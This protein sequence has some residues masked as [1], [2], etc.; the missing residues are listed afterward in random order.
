MSRILAVSQPQGNGTGARTSPEDYGRVSESKARTS[1][2]I[3]RSSRAASTSTRGPGSR[4]PSSASCSCTAELAA[5]SSS[6]AEEPQPRAG[7]HTYLRGPL[8][9]PAGERQCV[10][11]AHRRGHRGDQGAKAVEVDVQGM[12][13]RAVAG[14]A[15]AQQQAHVL[16]S[17]QREQAGVVGE[18]A[19][20]LPRADRSLAL[21]PQQRAGVDRSAARRHHQPVERA[22]PHGGVHGPP[23]GHRGE[24]G[25]RAEVTAH[26]PQPLQ[27][28]VHELARPPGDVARGSARGSRSVAARSAAPIRAAGR[29]PPPPRA[30]PRGRRCRSRR[31]GAVREV[32]RAPAP[33]PRAQDRC[34]EERG[35]RAPRS[36]SSTRS[37]TTTGARKACPPWTMRWATASTGG[38][39]SSAASSRAPPVAASTPRSSRS[40][41]IA[42]R[43][44]RARSLTLLDPT[45]TVSTRKPRAGAS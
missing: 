35:R 28:P 44:S 14:V 15:A 10:Q 42:S 39:S 6:S 26:D 4:P 45:L 37:S 43:A 23:A 24:R 11:P 17:R 12:A 27:R 3:S 5:S 30:S 8:P 34:A 22:E 40:T 31:R 25:S 20:G 16:R 1:R 38:R 7:A 18:R 29:S 41:R 2:A 32:A 9:H 19:L 13:G 33:A 21:G 36:R